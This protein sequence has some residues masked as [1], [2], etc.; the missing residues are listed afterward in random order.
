[1]DGLDP[2]VYEALTE[3]SQKRHDMLN[4][5]IKSI[6]EY[7]TLIQLQ[8]EWNKNYNVDTNSKSS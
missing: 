6:P 1:M 7:L 5:K 8:D 2:K 4:I 3:S